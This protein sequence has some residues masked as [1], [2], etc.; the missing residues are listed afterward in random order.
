MNYNKG[1]TLIEVTVYIGLF[2]ILVGGGILAAYNIIESNVINQSRLVVYDESNF[3]IS[4]IN[5]EVGGSSQIQNPQP[6][7]PASTLQVT[8]FDGSSVTIALTGDN[9]MITRGNTAPVA[10]NNQN[11]K[12]SNV[13]FD[14]QVSSTSQLVKT[15][16]TISAVADNGKI[17]SQDFNTVKY[18]RK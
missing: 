18:L 7:T 11:V 1:F 3:L 5:W 10:L 13:S 9:L 6:G 8:K 4:K 16:F 14:N 15:N 17:F 12:I 2:V